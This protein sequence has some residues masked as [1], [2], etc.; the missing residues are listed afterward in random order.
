MINKMRNWTAAASLFLFLFLL[1]LASAQITPN[2]WKKFIGEP[3]PAGTPDL[4]DFSYA[5]YKN[6]TEGIP[7]DFGYTVYNPI[8]RTSDFRFRFISQTCVV[9]TLS[10]Q[11]QVNQKKD[12]W[13]IES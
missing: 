6:G 5:G 4:I 9:P 12:K 11:F 13:K 7:E 2:I 3:V 8:L 1:P 10:K